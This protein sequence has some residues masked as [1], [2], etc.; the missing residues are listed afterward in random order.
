MIFAK[1]LPEYSDNCKCKS[2]E[3]KWYVT[4]YNVDTREFKGLQYWLAHIM[5]RS[6][7]PNLPDLNKE[8][9]ARQ[10]VVEF[11]KDPAQV[12]N[13]SLVRNANTLLLARGAKINFDKVMNWV[14]KS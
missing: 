8:L 11:F 9:A 5:I 1:N 14:G 10:I 6:N 13:S 3:V 7:I 4:L 12:S 2:D